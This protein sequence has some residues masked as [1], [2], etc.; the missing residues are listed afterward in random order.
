MVFWEHK[1]ELVYSLS[2]IEDT[3]VLVN[4]V[5]DDVWEYEYERRGSLIDWID[6]WYWIY[7]YIQ[8]MNLPMIST[9]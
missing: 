7:L 8:P 3:K 4:A 5:D 6:S 2:M 1:M 9:S